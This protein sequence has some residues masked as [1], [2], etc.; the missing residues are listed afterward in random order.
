MRRVFAFVLMAGMV[1][2]A[3]AQPQRGFSKRDKKF[4]VSGA[5]LDFVLPSAFNNT[6]MRNLTEVIGQLGFNVQTPVYKGFGIGG[7]VRASFFDYDQ[8][9]FQGN[10]RTGSVQRWSYYGKVQWEVLTS[11]K[12]FIELAARFGSTSYAFRTDSLGT[13]TSHGSYFSP[14][15]AWYLMATKNLAFGLVI[16]YEADG[17]YL[18]PEQFALTA[19]PNRRTGE[20]EGPLRYFTLGLSVSA[21]FRKGEEP[22]DYY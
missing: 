14:T 9:S 10:A 5:Q 19:L 1:L 20:T 13:H 16:G 22:V 2:G 3:T 18:V 6:Q 15:F 21:R 17:V 7:G 12:T 11:E 4:P 8:R